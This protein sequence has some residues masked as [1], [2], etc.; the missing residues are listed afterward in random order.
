[1]GQL[2]NGGGGDLGDRLREVFSAHEATIVFLERVLDDA[3]AYRP[4]Q[5]SGGSVKFA[6]PSGDYV[7]YRPRVETAVPA[8]PT[9]D[10]P[11][12]SLR[13]EH[14]GSSGAG[15]KSG[16]RRSTKPRG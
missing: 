10:C 8:C 1:M 9:H 5:G 13:E 2:L 4:P 15:L 16:G 6:C 12:Q 11:L 14:C 3:P 7:S